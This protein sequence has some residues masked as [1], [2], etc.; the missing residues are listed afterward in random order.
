MSAAFCLDLSL[1][2]ED[3]EVK[4]ACHGIQRAR[5][6]GFRVFTLE[7][8]SLLLV[9][10]MQKIFVLPSYFGTRIQSL[11]TEMDDCSFVDCV[12][13][14]KEV[15]V[16]RGVNQCWQCREGAARKGDQQSSG[17]GGIQEAIAKR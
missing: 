14:H 5:D 13:V 3:V 8:D 12:H 1:P 16:T 4:A 2:P 10:H 11:L 17:Q 7:S 15:T 9:N 6:A